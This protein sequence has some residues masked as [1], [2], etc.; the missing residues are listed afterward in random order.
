[1]TGHDLALDPLSVRAMR[2]PIAVRVT[3]AARDGV[4]DTLEGPVGYRARDALVSAG[5]GERWPVA[6][7]V[8]ERSYE[9]VEG[10]E[11]GDAVY[12]KR[13]FEVRARR[14]EHAFSVRVG[15]HGDLLRGQPGDWLVQ[16]EQGRYGI[17]AAELFART[18]EVSG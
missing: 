10:D 8:F 4:L 14:M 5:S 13:A 7:E 16:Y 12:R 15:H 3:L 11:A 2:R 6:R 1:M 18:Y 9:R 17:V